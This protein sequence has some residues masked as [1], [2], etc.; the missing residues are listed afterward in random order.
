[1]FKSIRNNLSHFFKILSIIILLIFILTVFLYNFMDEKDLANLPPKNK[2]KLFD[3]RFVSLFYYNSS[4][5][6][7][8]GDSALYP[9]SNFA[10]LY[11]AFYLIIIAAGIF[12]AI[13]F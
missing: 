3:N 6:G 11:T 1:M 7:G 2:N 8:L 5:H 4:I 13:D 12:T 9:I 10:K